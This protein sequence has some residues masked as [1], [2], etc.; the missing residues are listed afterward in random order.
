MAIEPFTGA[1]KRYESFVQNFKEASS[2]S[3]RDKSEFY[4]SQNLHC[5]LGSLLTAISLQ[6][7]NAAFGY[8]NPLMKR[9]FD[10]PQVICLAEKSRLDPGCIYRLQRL[11]DQQLQQNVPTATGVA[12]SPG[13]IYPGYSP[14]MDRYQNFGD[15]FK[16]TAFMSTPDCFP[17]IPDPEI[18]CCVG[19]LLTASTLPDFN[20]EL[21]HLNK[22]M[23]P[24]NAFDRARI[25][26]AAEEYLQ[27]P[28][29]ICH[30]KQ[31]V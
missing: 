29:L 24:G 30:L 4:F 12:I 28:E 3:A 21:A 22:C 15:E 5:C 23:G 1:M 25:I 27:N 26:R 31:L 13:C 9:P 7:V 2:L 10:L 6:D 14:Q 16:T 8:L 20:E 18:D 11:A 17:R 19:T